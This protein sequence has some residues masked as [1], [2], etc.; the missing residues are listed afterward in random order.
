MKRIFLFCFATFFHFCFSFLV[1]FKDKAV[2]L[3]DCLL[4]CFHHVPS[5]VDQ[6][7][8]RVFFSPV[9]SRV[10]L[11]SLV[12]FYNYQQET[13]DDLKDK[14]LAL[15]HTTMNSEEV[16]Q[17]ASIKSTEWERKK[18][19]NMNF[20][21]IW[22]EIKFLYPVCYKSDFILKPVSFASGYSSDCFYGETRLLASQDATMTLPSKIVFKQLKKISKVPLGGSSSAINLE[23]LRVCLFN[24]F[25]LCPNL[26]PLLGV[27]LTNNS[28]NKKNRQ[29]AGFVSEFATHGTLYDYVMQNTSII[30]IDKL[31]EGMCQLARGIQFLH[32]KGLVHRDIKA[33]NILVFEE[34]T[35]KFVFKLSDFGLCSPIDKCYPFPVPSTREKL[36]L[37][38]LIYPI[39]VFFN[40]NEN[41]SIN[42]IRS[43]IAIQIDWNMFGKTIEK[44]LSIVDTNWRVKFAHLRRLIENLTNPFYQFNSNNFLT[45]EKLFLA[46]LEEIQRNSDLAHNSSSVISLALNGISNYATCVSAD[47]SC[48][49]DSNSLS[50]PT[51]SKLTKEINVLML[52]KSKTN[53]EPAFHQLNSSTDE[54]EISIKALLC[55]LVI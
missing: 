17:N 25:H 37:A 21:A 23:E 48:G 7:V 9:S 8:P 51:S 52:K 26:H 41:I 35:D 10:F 39:E 13:I 3:P 20:F 42:P 1:E 14:Q 29:F 15:F 18:R 27:V 43:N 50:K 16:K 53:V 54:T 28:T 5:A 55:S 45:V 19:S 4:K 36:D 6:S 2:S 11:Q 24:D 44:V 33:N 40:S 22:N 31:L 34:G 49:S 30:Q 46:Q 47:L 12:L 38:L 32:E